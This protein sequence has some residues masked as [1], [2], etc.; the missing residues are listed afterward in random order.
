M[1][2][3]KKNKE[4][5]IMHLQ[6]FQPFFITTDGENHEGINTYKWFNADGLLCSVPE[7]LMI[8]IKSDGY[9]EDRNNVMYPL[10]NVVSIV[11]KLIDQKV[12]LDNFY[13]DFQ[14]AFSNKEVSKMDEYEPA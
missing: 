1:F 3:R 11:W 7:F 10:Q 8:D 4:P 5:K 2:W 9:L 14:V 6:R 12:V 13:H